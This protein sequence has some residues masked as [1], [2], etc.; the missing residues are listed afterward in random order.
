MTGN[1]DQY[2]EKIMEDLDYPLASRDERQT[3]AGDDGWKGKIVWM[4]PQK[5]LS[6]AAPLHDSMIKPDSMEKMRKRLGENLPTDPLTLRVD[7][8]SKKVTG[9]EGRHRA[10][11]AIEKGIESVPVFIFTGSLYT[12]T[13]KWTDD[14]HRDVEDVGNFKPE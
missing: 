12:R 9:H 6:L 7:M 1:F 3:Y 8:E 10:K 4:T 14:Q 2:Y 5:F 11:V 13:P